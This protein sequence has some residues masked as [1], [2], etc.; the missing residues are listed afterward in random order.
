MAQTFRQHPPVII[1]TF[2]GQWKRGDVEAT[3]LDHFTDSN[4]VD[5]I[6]ETSILTRPGIGPSQDVNVPLEDVKRIYNYNTGFANTQLVLTKD[7]A[8]GKIYH[9][10]SPT[11]TYGPILTIEGMDDFAFQPYGGRAYISP[12]S[13]SLPVLHAPVTPP[14]GTAVVGAGVEDGVHLYAVGFTNAAGTTIP[15]PTIAVTAANPNNQVDLTDILTGGVDVTARTLY[16]SKA[17]NSQLF[18]LATI[19]DNTTTVF[20]DNVADASLTNPAPAEN[21]AVNGDVAVEKGLQNEFLYVYAGDGTA[22]RKAAGAPLSGSMTIANGAAGFTDP[23]LHIFG[24]VSETISG[25]LTAPAA[26]QTFTTGA[27]LSVSF[28]SIPTS[29]D[30]NVVARHLVASKVISTYNGNLEGYDLFF[31]PNAT[32]PNNTD[33]FL[34][35]VSFFDQDLLDDASHLFDNYEEIPAGAVVSLYHERLVVA[36][37]FDDINLALVSAVGEPEAISQI[38]GLLSVQPDGNP[39][40]NFQE[41]RDVGYLFKR[42]RTIAYN[43][44][45]DE[46]STWLPV[47]VDNALGTFV[48]GIATVLDSGSASVDYLLVCTF[49]GISKFNGRYEEPELSWK[50]ENAWR[51]LDRDEFGKLQIVLAPIQKWIL[52]CLPDRSL[53]VGNFTNGMTAK[54]IAWET[55][56]FLP[57]I[58][59]VGIVNIDEIIIGADIA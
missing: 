55:W 49:Q 1:D 36:T 48:H 47:I 21:T 51:D 34:N 41:L 2:K 30:P 43:D 52:C 11:L 31:V 38:T 57:G 58:N 10:I 39:I 46:P 24:F 15:S 25:F 33:T 29:G 8:D 3:P 27:L 42:V 13:K 28:G 16:R 17:G 32:I 45:D 59:T 35:D 18:E 22:A 12:F 6:G 53:L 50:W 37:T 9:V 23:G 7:G 5:H 54:E 44:N 14:A 20:Q 19:A 40:T 4:N 56:T 26:L